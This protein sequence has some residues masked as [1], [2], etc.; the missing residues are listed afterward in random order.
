MN[1][2]LYSW[3]KQYNNSRILKDSL[4]ISD[5]DNTNYPFVLLVKKLN[6]A[7]HKVS[8]IDTE[9]LKY[10]NKIYKCYSCLS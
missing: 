6:D 1:I 9:D 5:G 4:A 8:T 2:G 10:Y 7:G 3:Y